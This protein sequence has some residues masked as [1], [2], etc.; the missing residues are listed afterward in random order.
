MRNEFRHWTGGVGPGGDYETM[1]SRFIT[2]NRNEIL[3]NIRERVAGRKTPEPSQKE[4]EE[5]IPIFL[6]Q[7]ADMLDKPPG[8]RE[9]MN[10]DAATRGGLLMARGYTVA[11]VVHDYGDVCQA[12]TELAVTSGEVI[13]SEDFR[14]LNMCLDDVIAESVTEYTRLRD[15]IASDGETERSGIFAHELRNKIS[16]VQMSFQHIQSGKIPVNGSVASVVTRNLN[17]MA[18]LINRTLVDVRLD[19]GNVQSQHV[20]LGQLML[21]AAHDGRITARAREITLTYDPLEYTVEVNADPQVMAGAIANLLQNAFKFTHMGG[22]VSLR[23]HQ[24]D[25]R[26]EIEVEDQCGGLPE[27]K[28]EKL[29]EA[30]KQTGKD[31]SGLGLGLFISRKGVEA[32]GGSIRVRD[33]PGHGCIFTI[34]IPLA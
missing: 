34:S 13:D 20:D 22:R 23:A 33:L 14:R 25:G 11:E 9:E 2:D 18:E 32:S 30:F 17:G 28:C 1:L 5:G 15:R 3:V 7:L 26:A 31:R 6:D 4:I 21:E 24:L 8:I 12:I 10:R 16:A 19:C 27:G 29:F